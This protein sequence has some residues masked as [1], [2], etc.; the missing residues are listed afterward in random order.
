MSLM[1]SFR[2]LQLQITMSAAEELHLPDSLSPFL[3][4][5]DTG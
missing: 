1:Q 5:T 4:P 2:V 3:C